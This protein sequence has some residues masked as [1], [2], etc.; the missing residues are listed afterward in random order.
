MR[1]VLAT[2]NRGKLR[3]FAAMLAPLG[4]ELLPQSALGIASVA[5]TG[6]TFVDNALIKARHAAGAAS[7]PAL[8]DD[9]GLE[10]DELNGEPGV[11]SARYAGESA[12]DAANVRKLLA[13]LANVPRERRGA[14]F[15]C[16]LALVRS[17]GDPH[18][19]VCEAAWRGCIALQPA[20][21]DG[22]GYDPVF[23]VEELGRTAA[24]LEADEKNLRSHRGQALRKLVGAMRAARFTP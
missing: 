6:A 19:L 3:E 10:V 1:V 23:F 21:T 7:L 13:R 4:I 2:G 5:E 20:G 11:H 17:A 12:D 16:A 15:R 9:S 14:S 18:P 8:A 22:F 24:Q